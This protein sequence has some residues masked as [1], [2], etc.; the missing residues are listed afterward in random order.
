MSRLPY[1]TTAEFD[2]H[3]LPEGLRRDHRTKAGTW[4]FVR[5]T[6]GSIRLR[7]DDGECVI[8]DRDHP[9][10]LAPG[11]THRVETVGPMRMIVEFYTEEP[12]T[13]A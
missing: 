13:R 7:F 1:K 5:V 3:T 9:V 12:V 2:Q 6:E 11:Q 8:A 10:V 4:G